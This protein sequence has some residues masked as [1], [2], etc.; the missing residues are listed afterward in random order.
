MTIAHFIGLDG[1]PTAIARA[2]ATV[3]RSQ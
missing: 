2:I 1:D 3:R